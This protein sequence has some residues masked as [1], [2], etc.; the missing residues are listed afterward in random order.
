MRAMKHFDHSSCNPTRSSARRLYY[1]Q[2]SKIVHTCRYNNDQLGVEQQFHP[3][4]STF[5]SLPVQPR[6]AGPIGKGKHMLQRRGTI[7][8]QTYASN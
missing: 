3:Q 2:H 6:L 1:I 4:K 8:F 7:I 5:V